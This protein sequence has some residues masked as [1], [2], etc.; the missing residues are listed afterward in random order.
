MLMRIDVL[1]E[2]LED[3]ETES[4]EEGDDDVDFGWK[5]QTSP[6]PPEVTLTSAITELEQMVS[7]DDP[8]SA[9]AL[10]HRGLLE[11]ARRVA[12]DGA[13]RL[14]DA[15]ELYA[16]AT[17]GT[18]PSNSSDFSARL[19]K[20]L[21]VDLFSASRRDGWMLAER[22]DDKFS[23]LFRLLHS[24]DKSSTALLAP[25]TRSLSEEEYE[26]L[27]QLMLSE[28]K[29]FCRYLLVKLYGPT[30]ARNKFGVHNAQNVV[31]RIHLALEK[32]DE[33]RSTT[34]SITARKRAHSLLSSPPRG[35]RIPW[36]KQRNGWAAKVV[37]EAAEKV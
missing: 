4:E 13:L 21:P 35:G 5:F 10:F 37:V 14:K 31:K 11:I 19:V 32:H 33:Q 34:T 30:A 27:E 9:D 1:Q 23:L 36:E 25:P 17:V 24:H 3:S 16:S 22:T 2:S 7:E 12:K 28:E 15:I 26:R 6:L 29:L 8:G 20:H 18:R